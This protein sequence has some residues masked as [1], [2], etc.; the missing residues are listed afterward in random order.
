M[1]RSWLLQ[2]SLLLTALLL[3]PVQS[4]HGCTDR[5]CSFLNKFPGRLKALRTSF[6][7]IR[8]YYEGKDDIETALL[9]DDMLS[10]FQSPFGCHA[11][12]DVLRFYLDTVLPTA[13]KE[14]DRKD[15]TYHIDNIGGIFNELKKEMLHCRNYFSCKK[16]FELDSIM[17]TYKKMQGQ[18]LYKAMGELGL[19]FN[20]IEEYMMSLK[21]KH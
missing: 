13:I 10:D 5:C 7:T 1:S 12:N 3:E 17:T 15:Y 6:A 8:D 21:P 2:L 11:I 18:G 9:D 20:Y 4:R 14:K 16:P 19:L